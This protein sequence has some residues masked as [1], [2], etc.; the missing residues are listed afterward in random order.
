MDFANPSL[1]NL[2]FFE[3]AI[4]YREVYSFLAPSISVLA[5]MKRV[6]FLNVIVCCRLFTCLGLPSDV[7][8]DS[9]IKSPSKT[10]S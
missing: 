9:F 4:C 5:Y 10:L 2:M 3:A 6:V 8:G 1:V 7:S